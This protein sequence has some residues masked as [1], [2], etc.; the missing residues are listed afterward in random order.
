MILVLH[1]TVLEYLIHLDNYTTLA[2]GTYD[3][4]TNLTTFTNKANWIPDVTSPNNK[5]VVIDIDSGAT[6]VGRY[7]ETTLLG[8]NPNDD[9]TLPGDW[10]TGT[11]YIGYLYDYQVR[12]SY[13]ISYTNTRR[14][15]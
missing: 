8:N 10:S 12:L 4:G 15:V 5:L 9:F 1:K 11:F 13:Y 14:K 3:S 7:A 6:R 2:A